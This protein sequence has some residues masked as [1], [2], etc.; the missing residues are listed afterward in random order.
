MLNVVYVKNNPSINICPKKSEN[1][2]L[3]YN[4]YTDDIHH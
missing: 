1:V 4:G 3:L 2:V